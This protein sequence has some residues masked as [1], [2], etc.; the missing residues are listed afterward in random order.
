MRLGDPEAV[1]RRTRGAPRRTERVTA[2]FRPAAEQ[3]PISVELERWVY[4]G[5]AIDLRE[6]RVWGFEVSAAPSATP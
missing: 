2:A 4:D 3:A 6:G 1:V 5:L